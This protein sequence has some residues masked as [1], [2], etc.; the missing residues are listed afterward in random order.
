MATGV[1][2]ASVPDVSLDSRPVTQL[3][4]SRAFGDLALKHPPVI[5]STPEVAVHDIKD[6]DWC[7]CCYHTLFV[8]FSRH[9][10][11]Q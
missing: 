9:F 11:M 3:S 2:R 10:H 8:E 1:W 4:V 6:T 5:I 7:D